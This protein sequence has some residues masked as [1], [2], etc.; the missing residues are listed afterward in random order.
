MRGPSA[1][2]LVR[3]VCEMQPE[4]DEKAAA[5]LLA[6]DDELRAMLEDHWTGGRVLAQSLLDL[7][8]T[9]EGTP[10]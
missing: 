4:L 1:I 6:L 7:H 9:L 10:A 5:R 2:E 3:F 8:L